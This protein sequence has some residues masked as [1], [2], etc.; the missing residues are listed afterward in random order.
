[1]QRELVAGQA[2]EVMRQ[3]VDRVGPG[4][5]RAVAA[6]VGDF[7]AEGQVDFFAGLDGHELRLALLQRGLAAVGIDGHA[8]VDQRPV[9]LEQ[10]VHAVGVAAGLLVG[11]VG[12]D[13]VAPRHEALLLQAHDGGQHGGVLAQ[14]VDAAAAVQPAVLFGQRERVVGPVGA[15]GLDH[16][17]VADVEQRP[18]S[19][20]TT[21]PLLG[22]SAGASSCTSSRA[23]PAASRRCSISSA[24][25]VEPCAW[26]ASSATSWLS[27]SRA[28]LLESAGGSGAACALAPRA[29]S[30][31]AAMRRSGRERTACRGMAVS[32][33]KNGGRCRTTARW[34]A[35]DDTESATIKAEKRAA[36]GGPTLTSNH[37]AYHMMTRSCGARYILSPGLTSKAS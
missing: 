14:H 23:K 34:C 12:D 29:S 15:L 35:V 31:A 36:R 10:P 9:F 32:F 11:R 17:E 1:M 25:R 24:E 18:R 28:S 21:L 8:G 26:V 6:L 4:R 5:Q 13:D 20:T 22:W 19:R 2:V 7:Q 33:K 16:V 37:M 3:A 27:T 30:V